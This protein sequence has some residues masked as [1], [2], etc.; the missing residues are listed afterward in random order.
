MSQKASNNP[1]E[2]AWNVADATKKKEDY[3]RAWL[4]KPW[5]ARPLEQIAN[6][7]L[8]ER[9]YREACV[10]AQIGMTLPIADSKH[11]FELR[12]ILS[13][14]SYYTGN[15]EEGLEQAEFLHF[16]KESPYRLALAHNNIFYAK[17]L[18]LSSKI[19]LKI[20][21]EIYHP[22]NPSVYKYGDKIYVTVR[23]VNYTIDKA[24]V[25]RMDDGSGI[26]KTRNYLLTYADKFVLCEKP[27]KLQDKGSNETK[28]QGIEDIRLYQ[29]TDDVIFGYGTR[30][31]CGTKQAGIYR[32]EWNKAGKLLKQTLLSDGTKC[33]KNWLPFLD[34]GV[35]KHIYSHSPFILSSENGVLINQKQ[36]LDLSHFRGGASPIWFKD[37][38]LWVIH[39]V[40]TTP[41]QTKRKYFHRWVWSDKSF[42]N[43]CFSKPFILESHQVEFIAGLAK[44]DNDLLISY[45]IED[46]EAWLGVIREKEIDN[47][48]D[49]QIQILPQTVPS[50]ASN[51]DTNG[52]ALT[53][54][55]FSELIVTKF[56]PEDPDFSNGVSDFPSYYWNKYQFTHI[57]KP[58]RVVEIGVRAGYG[59]W[60][61][62][63]GYIPESYIG[64]D[65][66]EDIGFGSVT[67]QN[68]FRKWAE[69]LISEL[70]PNYELR[71]ANS[72]N[73]DRFPEADFYHVDGEHSLEGTYND[74][75]KCFSAALVNGY[76][77]V[78]DFD[79]IGQVKAAT[80]KFCSQ[81]QDIKWTYKPSFRGEFLIQKINIIP[82]TDITGIWLISYSNGWTRTYS[83]RNDDTVICKEGNLRGT[84]K[85]CVLTFPDNK[86]ETIRTQ[87]NNLYILHYD[88]KSSYPL[89]PLYAGVGLKISD[90]AY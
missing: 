9:K 58:K 17:K 41:G 39:E 82:S 79:Y 11:Q 61:F 5:S 36:E 16:C 45:G 14:G 8:D 46:K 86:L 30:W 37:R 89:S 65:F 21:S 24:G 55:E 85:E 70:T 28:V 51:K 76:I 15:H 10:L 34:E 64:V 62:L 69:N 75:A 84:I 7:L 27:V 87:D 40:F 50:V 71:I 52:S 44:I 67:L 53:E 74:I 32:L 4:L 42:K 18:N 12:R 2:D 83:I 54:K 63:K 29:V 20:D 3:L 1:Y 23:M 59:A 19:E 56:M 22:M 31:D 57:I 81:H 78:D 25:N 38:W 68:K 6:Q 88:Q 90:F 77:L 60:S 13:I 66:Y 47:Y 48:L 49:K 73:L 33:E 35:L 26:Y 80:L 72:Q 43:I